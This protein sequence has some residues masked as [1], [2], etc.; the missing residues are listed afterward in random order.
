LLAVLAVAAFWLAGCTS[1]SPTAG[2]GGANLPAASGLLAASATAMRGVST[3]H[4][5]LNVNGTLSG[6]PVQSAEGDLNSKGQAK[7][8][9]KIELGQLVQVDFVLY[10][11]SFYIK[12]PTGGY[13]KISASLAGAMFDPS[14]ILS[15]TKGVARLLSAVRNPTTEAKE[16]V[17]GTDTYR[18]SGTV[19]KDAVGSLV[20][21]V[22]ADVPAKIWISADGRNLPVKAEFTVPGTDGSQAAT[23]DVTISNVN[24]PVTV[25]PPA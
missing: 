2:T 25:S 19:P 5:T 3:V 16:S 22:N 4:F 20:P 14:A 24:E 15:P 11:S 21:G 1:S 6:V 13:Q 17:G 23:V 18:V 12:G 9:A 7:G 10:G 8:N